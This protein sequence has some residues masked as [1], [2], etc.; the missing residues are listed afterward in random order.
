VLSEESLDT[1]FRFIV[2]Q[3]TKGPLSKPN[4][5][6]GEAAF[7]RREIVPLVQAIVARAE[8]PEL[9]V[10]GHYTGIK[11]PVHYL[12]VH[13]HPDIAIVEY[14]RRVMA[15]EVKF[16][17]SIDRSGSISKSVG[18]ASIYRLAGYR[19]STALLLDTGRSRLQ[20]HHLRQAD[21]LGGS[22]GHFAVVVRS[23]GREGFRPGTVLYPTG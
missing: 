8:V 2:T 22:S 10:G 16:L 13:F 7:T 15:I 19:R 17:G 21:S 18:Q 12:G 1:L 6:E 20:P 11:R 5:D 14:E 4:A 9:L 3:L 23:L